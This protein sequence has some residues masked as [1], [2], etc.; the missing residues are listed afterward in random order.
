MAGDPALVVSMDDHST[1]YADSQAA[2]R[3]GFLTAGTQSRSF[4]DIRRRHDI[5]A[6]FRHANLTDDLTEM[7]ARLRR[8][9]L[10]VIVVNQTTPEHHIGGFCCETGNLSVR[11]AARRA[12]DLG[13]SPLTV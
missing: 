12:P 10:D 7:V 3:L 8:H 6:A 2:S 13:S 9:R 4:A 11:L 5:D 1:L